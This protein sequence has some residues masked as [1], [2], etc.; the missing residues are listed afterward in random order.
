MHCLHWTPS[1]D[2]GPLRVDL[3]LDHLGPRRCQGPM[4]ALQA[5]ISIPILH[6]HSSLFNQF[7]AQF[8]FKCSILLTE[9]SHHRSRQWQRVSVGQL[10]ST[11]CI[12]ERSHHRCTACNRLHEIALQES[13]WKLPSTHGSWSLPSSALVSQCSGHYSVGKSAISD[14]FWVLLDGSLSPN[15]V[16][17]R[18]GSWPQTQVSV[19]IAS[20]GS[21]SHRYFMDDL[22]DHQTVFSALIFDLTELY[23]LMGLVNILCVWIYANKTIFMIQKYQI[24]IK[25]HI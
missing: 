4:E 25:M 7:Y 21:S 22:G 6:D 23:P 8:D 1:L 20:I 14:S 18:V 17:C 16:I 9:R 11:S 3:F 15:C 10:P 24:I 5:W 19:T 2:N 12:T 13:V